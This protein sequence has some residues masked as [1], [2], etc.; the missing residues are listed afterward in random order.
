MS[1]KALTIKFSLLVF[2]VALSCT[3]D[4]HSSNPIIDPELTAYVDQFVKEA[5]LRGK[6]ILLDHLEVKFASLQNGS[7]GLGSIDPLVVSIDKDCW[8]VLPDIAKEILMFHELGH[9]ILQRSHDNNTLPNGVYKTIM[10]PD[11]TTLYNEYTPEKRVYYLDEL[12]GVVTTLPAWTSTKTIE[13]I[14]LTEEI[15]SNSLWTYTISG[16]ANHKGAIVDSIF[17]SSSNSLAIHSNERATGFSYWHY[18]W[19]PT[20]IEEGSALLLKVKIKTVNLTADGA[21]FAF[22][23]DVNE[24]DYPIFFYTTQTK[25][26]VGST[27]FE[28][29]Y[30]IKVNYFPS[31][32]DKLNI[33][34]ILDG[35]AAG[36]VFFD[37]IRVLKYQ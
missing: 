25:P 10:Y 1:F 19:V 6:E 18:S 31:H 16:A 4:E 13:S 36:T 15:A 27:G 24:K 26:I 9:S 20:G 32:V 14:V 30:S 7:C 34:L 28:S 35:T 3:D 22:R 29:E 12:F 17:S 8:N 11:P 5:E 21:Y 23:A 33:F 37:D 2:Y